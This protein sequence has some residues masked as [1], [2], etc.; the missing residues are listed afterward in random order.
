MTGKVLLSM[1]VAAGLL[2]GQEALIEKEGEP[3]VAAPSG[4]EMGVMR[5]EPR[6]CAIPLVTFKPAQI[7]RM[8]VMKPPPHR[9]SQRFFIAPPAPPCEDAD[10]YPVRSGSEPVK[11]DRSQPK[12]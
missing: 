12:Q 1:L 7:P 11:K 3:K 6:R 8:P 9:T 2:A 5:G 4:P 10:R